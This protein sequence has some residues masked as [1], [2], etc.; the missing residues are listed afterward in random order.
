M[1]C[2]H[3][4]LIPLYKLK[5]TFHPLT[6]MLWPHCLTFASF[7]AHSLTQSSRV[8]TKHGLQGAVKLANDGLG[9]ESG[10]HDH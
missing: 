3:V 1:Q 10:V 4:F 9:G 8:N 6:A 7:H 2:Q 5:Q